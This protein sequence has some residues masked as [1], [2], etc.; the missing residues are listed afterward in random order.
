MNNSV[1]YNNRLFRIIISI[2]AGFYIVI[3]GTRFDILRALTSPMFYV[4][5]AISCIVAWLLVSYVHYSTLKLDAR[6]S[7]RS[8]FLLRFILQFVLCLTVPILI[9]L[10]I[11]SV[12]FAI[13]GQSIFENGF[14][15]A[16]IPFVGVLLGLLSGYYCIHYFVLTDEQANQFEDSTRTGR[17]E[18][19]LLDLKNGQQIYVNTADIF[20]FYCVGKDVYMVPLN[21]ERFEV[22]A[23]I[24]S[25]QNLLKNSDLYRIN[26]SVIL[27]F[28]SVSGYTRGSKRNTLELIFTPQYLELVRSFLPDQFIVTNDH[29]LS[30]KNRLR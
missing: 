3:Y 9:D 29:V 27:N 7:W 24:S 8:D 26:R 21:G 19:F 25:L 30:I 13:I 10:L 23:N 2:S 18:T 11:F 15:Y 22:F 6:Y 16:D 28:N 14:F 4:V 1:S 17:V 12:Y 20:C 5:V